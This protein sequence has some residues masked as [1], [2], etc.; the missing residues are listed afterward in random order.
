MRTRRCCEAVVAST[1][2]P[3]RCS[4]PRCSHPAPGK[5]SGC[6]GSSDAWSLT[7]H[8]THSLLTG[9]RFAQAASVGA[10]FPLLLQSLANKTVKYEKNGNFQHKILCGASRGWPGETS[11]MKIGGGCA[12][13]GGMAVKSGGTE[14]PGVD[15][16]ADGHR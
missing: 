10:D 11:A 14:T 5:S 15:A 6:V 9:A 13:D 8:F 3:P 1:I 4:A 7:Q 12:S 16:Q 2:A